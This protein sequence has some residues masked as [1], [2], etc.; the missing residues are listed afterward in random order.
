M[1]AQHG[2]QAEG[3][4]QHAFQAGPLALAAT[5]DGVPVPDAMAQSERYEFRPLAQAWVRA[6]C[7]FQAW[8]QD[9]I[10]SWASVPDAMAQSEQ[11]EFRA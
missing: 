4:A 5:P 6:L 8:A 7:G 1:R 2:F 9:E 10:L 11:H 3:Q